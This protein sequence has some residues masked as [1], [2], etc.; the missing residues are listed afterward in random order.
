MQSKD[1]LTLIIAAWG[2]I[3]GTIALSL[4]IHKNIKYRNRLIINCEPIY[5]VIKNAEVSY[6]FIVVE[7]SNPGT[8][9]QSLAEFPTFLVRSSRRSEGRLLEIM[10]GDCL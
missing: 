7:I 4:N 3:T 10:L 9:T 5:R 8:R 1:L 6:Y 2:A